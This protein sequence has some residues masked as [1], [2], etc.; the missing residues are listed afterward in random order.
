MRQYAAVRAA[1]CACL[2]QCVAVSLVVST[3]YAHAVRGAVCGGAIGSVRQ[4]VCDSAAVYGNAAVGG[5]ALCAAVCAAECG[6]ECVAVRV[7]VLVA[8][9]MVVCT[10]CAR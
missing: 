1:E 3:Q 8:V 6:R 10:Q 5:S 7:A 9:R 2:W 4:C